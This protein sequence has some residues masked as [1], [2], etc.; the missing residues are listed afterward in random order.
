M[1]M[2]MAGLAAFLCAGIWSVPGCALLRASCPVPAPG[3][4]HDAAAAASRACAAAGS[5]CRVCVSPVPAG[6]ARTAGSRHPPVLIRSSWKQWRRWSGL[7]ELSA[8]TAAAAAASD[9]FP[10][11]CSGAGHLE[12]RPG[13]GQEGAGFPGHCCAAVLVSERS[14]CTSVRVLWPCL[15]SSTNPPPS[16]SGLWMCAARPHFVGAPHQFPPVLPFAS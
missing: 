7:C 16:T 8:A 3:A 9:A 5:A 12:V 6:P 4:G 11:H 14:A 10:A 2:R 15:C 13:L 1:P